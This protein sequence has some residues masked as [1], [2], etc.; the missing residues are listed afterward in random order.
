MPILSKPTMGPAVAVVFITI[1]ALLDVWSAIWYMWLLNHRPEPN[2]L[3]Y[4]CS[5]TFL[6]GLVVLL[7]GLTIGQI[8]RSARQAE[9]PPQEVT[10]TVKKADQK[11]AEKGSAPAPAGPLGQP[12]VPVMVVA[13]PPVAGQPPVVRNS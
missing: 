5:G 1:G 11:L 7:I 8:G 9:L 10:E 4:V 6:S 12:G 3:Y 13:Q 2:T